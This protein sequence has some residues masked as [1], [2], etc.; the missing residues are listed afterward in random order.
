[1]SAPFPTKVVHGIVLRADPQREACFTVVDTDAE[2]QE[3]PDMS[4]ISQRERLHRHMNNELGALEIAA[5]CVADFSDAPWELR[6]QLARQCWDESR[7]VAVLYR[8]LRELD[9]RKGEFPI[10]NFEWGI[11]C[12]LDTLAGRLAVQNR[13]FEAGEMDFL[14]K[15]PGKWREIGDE[16][17]AEML[18]GI[19]V[20][21]IQHVRFANDWLKKLVQQDRRLVLKI[22]LAARFLE[23]VTAAFAPREGATNAAGTDMMELQIKVP[24]VNIEDRRSAGFSEDEIVAI[25]R[26]SGFASLAA[27]QGN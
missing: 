3:W 12:A 10:S 19:L 16:R 7:H 13:T 8:R 23:Q 22:A 5:Q 17:T 25:L 9:G 26:K 2:L 14:S 20:D 4:P 21:E 6:M 1:M 27:E 18:E 24:A 11:T 15:I